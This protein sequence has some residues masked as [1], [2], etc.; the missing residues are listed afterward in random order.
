MSFHNSNKTVEC[1]QRGLGTGTSH[2]AHIAQQGFG[3]RPLAQSWVVSLI[4]RGALVQKWMGTWCAVVPPQPCPPHDLLPYEWSP[5][6]S[7]VSAP[8]TAHSGRARR[9]LKIELTRQSNNY[10]IHILQEERWSEG[11]WLPSFQTTL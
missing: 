2:K 3:V 7:W 1:C 8:W 11:T 9:D 4:A 5:E 6:V 10:I